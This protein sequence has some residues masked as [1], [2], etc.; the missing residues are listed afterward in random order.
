[1]L[2]KPLG[3]ILSGLVLVVFVAVVWFALQMDPIGGSGREEIVTVHLG[4]SISTIAGE[5][6]AK[7][8]IA[9]PFAFR[10]DTL[11]FGAPTVQPGSYEVK[12]GSSF[13]T[14]RSILGTSPNVQVVDVTPGLMLSEVADD[15]ASDAGNSFG[16]KFLAA[17]TAAAA[18]SAYGPHGSLEG[19]IGAGQ[20]VITPQETPSQ[21]VAA[22]VK[23]FQQEATSVG[24]TPTTRVNGL[25]AYQLVT[26]ASIDEK[27]GYYPRYMPDVARVIYN[28]LAQGMYLRM[29]STV[30]Y[31]FK[32]DGGTVTPAMLQTSTPYNTYLHAGLTPT[33]ICTVSKYSL[34]AVLDP[35]PGPWLY[36]TVVNRDGKT[37][38]ASTFAQQLQ[39]EKLAQK[40]GI[41]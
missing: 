9:S 19:L 10:I 24:L 30:L 16:A 40:N 27:E 38:F 4:D 22:M 20:Y 12:Q 41:E 23:S 6:H 14:L 28:R 15:V 11:I 39:N 18:S 36:F 8:V 13:A 2:T 1:M 25:D 3:R 29:D 21:L 34:R 35:P 7:G 26:A 33:P 32:Q 5:L 37:L 17:A 31:Y